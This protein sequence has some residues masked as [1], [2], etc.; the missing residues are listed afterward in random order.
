[1]VGKNGIK[2]ASK[3]AS[4][5]KARTTIQHQKRDETLTCLRDVK[6]GDWLIRA[7][8]TSPC[9]FFV[10]CFLGPSSKERNEKVLCVVGSGGVRVCAAAAAAGGRAPAF[11]ALALRLIACEK[12][13]KL[14]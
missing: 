8:A 2:Q 13:E 11:L 3:Q 12:V 6:D 14:R 4:R 9:F 5:K 10:L 1:M 7:G